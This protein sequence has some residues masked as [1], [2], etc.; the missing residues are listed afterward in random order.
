MGE[1]E[2]ALPMSSNPP[3]SL[4]PVLTCMANSG[5]DV[6][7][8]LPRRELLASL[9]SAQ[10]VNWFWAEAAKYGWFVWIERN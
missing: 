4:P 5:V 10:L 3:A 8:P 7:S 1:R 2:S 6:L 9:P